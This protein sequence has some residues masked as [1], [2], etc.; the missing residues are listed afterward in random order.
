MIL[1]RCGEVISGKINCI[2][3][4]PCRPFL[5]T[6]TSIL[7]NCSS[8]LANQCPVSLRLEGFLPLVM[9]NVL[10]RRT[11]TKLFFTLWTHHHHLLPLLFFFLLPLLLLLSCQLDFF[12]EKFRY[13]ATCSCLHLCAL[14]KASKRTTVQPYLY[15]GLLWLFTDQLHAFFVVWFSSSSFQ[16]KTSCVFSLGKP[17]IFWANLFL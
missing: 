14:V 13:S 10:E 4:T 1:F 2:L 15:L 3:C 6:S 9:A 8:V 16:T 11:R 7:Y 12:T 17:S 5:I